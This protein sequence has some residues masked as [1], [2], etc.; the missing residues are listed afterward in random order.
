M[1]TRTLSLAW[2]DTE[3]SRQ[4][5]PVGRLDVDLDAESARY[6][7]RYIEG[8]RRAQKEAKFPPLIDFPDLNGDYQTNELFALFKNRVIATGRPDRMDYLR[9]LG[10]EQDADPI[11]VLSV[12]GG[13]RAT[14]LYEVFP[15]IVQQ[16]DGSFRCRF[17]LHGWRHVSAGAQKR[18]EALQDNEE[19]HL[20]LELTNPATRIAIQVQTTD[21]HVIGWAPRYLLTDLIAAMTDS[22]KYS[23][24]VVRVNP[25]PAPSRQR[26]LI[27]MNGRWNTYK[28]MEGGDYQPLVP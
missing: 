16:E 9:G 3:A 7:F 4:W 15:R 26:V 21:Y 13:Y 1:T 18:I 14:D 6:R 28:P 19:L 20:T 27:E 12:S 25:L 11:E 17:F 8:A 24:R 5:F 2:Q 23:A 10:L 22:P